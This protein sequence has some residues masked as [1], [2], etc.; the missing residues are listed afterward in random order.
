MATAVV[1]LGI[2]T[3]PPCGSFQCAQVLPIDM[4]QLWPYGTK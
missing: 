1:G 2:A 3:W 4:S